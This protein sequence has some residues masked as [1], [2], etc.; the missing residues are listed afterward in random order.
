MTSLVGPAVEAM[1]DKRVLKAQS[2]IGSSRVEEF[3]T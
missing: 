3:S 1:W 2:C